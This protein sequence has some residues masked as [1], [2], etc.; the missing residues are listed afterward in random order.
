MKFNLIIGLLLS[1]FFSTAFAA[2]SR[3]IPKSNHDV[4]SWLRMP[5]DKFG[6]FLEKEF[7]Y[8]DKK[9]NCALKNY[10]N[11]GGPC[12]NT[13]SYYEG[14][15]FPERLAQRVHPLLKSIELEWEHGELRSVNFVFNR[16]VDERDIR[17]AFGL[18]AGKPFSPNI[19][20]IDIQ[21]CS[22]QSNC[23]TLQGFD[24]MGAGEAGCGEDVG[25]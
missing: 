24:H 21:D 4:L 23:L 12:K 14:P 2:E 11:T 22:K 13:S 20:T 17:S 3:A 8:K 7:G 1:V 5:A 10:A 19:M 6:C 9:F 16:K 18:P 15:K 25:K